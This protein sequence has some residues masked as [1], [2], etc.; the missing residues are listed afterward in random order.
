MA[1]FTVIDHEELTGAAASW[2]SATIPSSYDHLYLTISARSSLGTSNWYDYVDVQFN[3][4][5]GTNYSSTGVYGQASA[6]SWRTS[7]ADGLDRV[8][9]INADGS[10]ADTFGNA[11]IW[12]PNYA[13]TANFKQVVAG[14]V[15]EGA[16]TTNG[17]WTMGIGAG[18]WSS[19]AAITSITIDPQN[20][21]LMQ[22]SSFTLYGVT[23]A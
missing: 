8:L 1:A 9:L 14:F 23:G 5:T 2:T 15:T 21:D 6:G 3:G 4:D 22:Y 11:S 13:N 20:G 17:Y 18:L 7:G 19:T 16:T 10:T 12:I